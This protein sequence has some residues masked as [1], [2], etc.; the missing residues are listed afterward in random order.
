MIEKI[1]N[2]FGYYKKPKYE[3]YDQELANSGQPYQRNGV[4]YNKYDNVD[5]NYVAE[6]DEIEQHKIESYRKFDMSAVEC[7]RYL[8]FQKDHRSCRIAE[9]G[10]HKF[11]AIGGGT[12]VTFMG[13]GLGPIVHCHCEACGETVDITD[14]T[15]W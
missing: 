3:P 15:N 8:Q 13:T 12:T 11:G 7:A 14:N 2:K 4:W 5:D 10:R 6:L 9:D 1:L